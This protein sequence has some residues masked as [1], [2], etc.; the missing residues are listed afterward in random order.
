VGVYLYLYFFFFLEDSPLTSDRSDGGRITG[1]FLVFDVGGESLK[2]KSGASTSTST[3]TF[4]FRVGVYLYLYLPLLGGGLPLPLLFLFSGRL[5]PH[6]ESLGWRTHHRS[7]PCVV[8][9]GG[10]SLKKKSG[11]LYLHLYLHLPLLGGGLPLPLLF[12][13]FF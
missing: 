4:R 9:V 7:L 2:K 5:P 12:L 13:V 6:V 1:P 3:S 8:D 11:S 10:E